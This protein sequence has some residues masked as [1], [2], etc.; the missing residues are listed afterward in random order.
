MTMKNTARLLCLILLLTVLLSGCSAAAGPETA[1]APRQTAPVERESTPGKSDPAASGSM[2]TPDGTTPPPDESTTAPDD[3]DG[4]YLLVNGTRI[5]LGM[6]F[7]DVREALGAQTAPDEELRN[8]D[9]SF[10][11]TFHFYPDLTVGENPDGLIYG[12]EVNSL[13]EGEGDAALMGK[14]RIGTTL[15]EAL[16][17]LGKPDNETTVASDCMLIYQT[18]D[19]Y[20]CV[21]LDADGMDA[22][23]GIS[24]SLI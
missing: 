6:K 8:C 9:G 7:A 2:A 19:Q 11:G 1:A 24:M 14:V 10:F 22:V 4:M 20:I 16:A 13:F 3:T 12:I 18:Y 15:E 5:T 23:S 21:F 17:V